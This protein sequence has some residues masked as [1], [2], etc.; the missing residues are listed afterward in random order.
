MQSLPYG[1]SPLR[2][3]VAIALLGAIALPAAGQTRAAGPKPDGA[4]DPF[5]L[6]WHGF[7]RNAQHSAGA[8]VASQPR[9][10]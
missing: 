6:M 4:A 3:L 1:R 8:P 5:Y 2:L 10:Q 7:A 9:R